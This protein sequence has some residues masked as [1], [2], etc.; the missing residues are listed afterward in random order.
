MT[1]FRMYGNRVQVNRYQVDYIVTLPGEEGKPV[2]T[3]VSRGFP[4]LAEAEAVN[5]QYNGTLKELDAAPYLWLDGLEFQNFD[6]A[7]KAMEMGEK[8]YKKAQ[9]EQEAAKPE[10]QITDLQLAMVESYESTAQQITD[11][12]LALAELYE[13]GSV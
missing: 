8:A 7:R 12:Q 6:E 9:E 10:S 11:I 2:E 1:I 13:R 3:A 4:T 5:N